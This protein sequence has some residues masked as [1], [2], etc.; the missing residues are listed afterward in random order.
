MIGGTPTKSPPKQ[1]KV[2]VPQWPPQKKWLDCHPQITSGWKAYMHSV[3]LH[4]PPQDPNQVISCLN[5]IKN[6]RYAKGWNK[7]PQFCISC[8]QKLLFGLPAGYT[9]RSQSNMGTRPWC[10]RNRYPKSWMLGSL[11][12]VEFSYFPNIAF[13]IAFQKCAQFHALPGINAE[14]ASPPENLLIDMISFIWSIHRRTYQPKL[15]K[16]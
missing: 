9:C 1:V 13:D 8:F 10:L 11:L 3:S 5:R 7:T 12:P 14:Q 15:E 4:K 16:C 2:T 6:K